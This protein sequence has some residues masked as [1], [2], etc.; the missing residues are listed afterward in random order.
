MQRPRQKPWGKTA[1]TCGLPYR[2][3][4][5]CKSTCPGCCGPAPCSSA[6]VGVKIA[7]APSST[8]RGT[9]DA[10]FHRAGHVGHRQ[11][12]LQRRAGCHG[13]VPR[14]LS[15]VFIKN[16]PTTRWPSTTR[17]AD[18]QAEETDCPATD[19]WPPWRRYPRLALARGVVQVNHAQ[20]IDHQDGGHA[21]RHPG[22]E[23]GQQGRILDGL[24]N[25]KGSAR[26]V[27]VMTAAQPMAS[28][29]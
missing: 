18:K 11:P 2:I 29:I 12:L 6:P 22:V 13:G 15:A 1:C 27:K 9:H 23:V 17:G 10:Y 19:A 28:A 26:R 3:A 24:A 7:P 20:A 21:Q 5:R 4:P 16:G 8:G 14:Q 25:G